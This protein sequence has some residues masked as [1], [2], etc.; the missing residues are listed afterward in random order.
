MQEEQKAKPGS[1]DEET[2]QQAE[3]PEPIFEMKSTLILG[4]KYLTIVV[5]YLG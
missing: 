5:G 3:T 1:S 2:G 4:M